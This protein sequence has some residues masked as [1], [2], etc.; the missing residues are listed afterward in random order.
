MLWLVGQGLSE[1]SRRTPA[2]SQQDGEVP[3]Y[4]WSM[5]VVT[6]AQ[7]LRHQDVNKF[8]TWVQ[9]GRSTTDAGDGTLA[10]AARRGTM[11]TE[12]T[13]SLVDASARSMGVGSSSQFCCVVVGE[14]RVLSGAGG[15]ASRT[16]WCG[17][18]GQ[19]VDPRPTRGE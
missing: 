18:R 14:P 6:T 17:R 12:M 16:K 13:F 15:H 3:P 8:G 5:L 1:A 7:L 10:A 2:A 4:P 9:A 19:E 11:D